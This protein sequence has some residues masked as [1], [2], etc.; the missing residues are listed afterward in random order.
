MCY[1]RDTVCDGIILT[2][3]PDDEEWS[4]GIGFKCIRNDKECLLPQQFLYDDVKDCQRGDDL[5]F[6]FGADGTK[7]DTYCCQD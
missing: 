3:C 5:C 6:D 4:T 1:S 7:Y 2:G